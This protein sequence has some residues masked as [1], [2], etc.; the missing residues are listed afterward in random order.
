MLFIKKNQSFPI[1]IFAKLFYREQLTE[2]MFMSASLDISV[3]VEPWGATY[4]CCLLLNNYC[5]DHSFPHF[6]SPSS[7][8]F[9]SSS[10]SFPSCSSSSTP[11][12]P[13]LSS[14]PTLPAFPFVHLIFSFYSLSIRLPLQIKLIIKV[15]LL[16]NIA[17]LLPFIN[18][19]VMF[20]IFSQPNFMGNDCLY[21]TL[22]KVD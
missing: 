1:N 9:P 17:I 18:N 4:L 19:K 7:L 16:A 15:G 20:W 10:Y 2:N 13:F 12:Q 6:S 3:K 22:I 14:V 11:P 21:P 5:G 8:P